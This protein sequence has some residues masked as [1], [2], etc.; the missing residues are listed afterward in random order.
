M[1]CRPLPLV[2]ALKEPNGAATKGSGHFQT[3]AKWRE[4]PDSETASHR[5][6]EN[7]ILRSAKQLPNR[8]QRVRAGVPVTIGAEE[9]TARCAL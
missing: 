9:G 4:S 8:G 3:C 2:V 1:P 7:R 6:R 5:A